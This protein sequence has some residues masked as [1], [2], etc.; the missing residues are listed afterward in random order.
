MYT[1]FT[2]P[3]NTTPVYEPLSL[4][5]MMQGN[6]AIYERGE[7]NFQKIQGLIDAAY[8]LPSLQGKDTEVKNK[9]IQSY[10]DNVAQLA[11]GNLTDP[12]SA[13]QIENY[14]SRVTRDP[15][16][17]NIVQ[18][19][20]IVGQE[21]KKRAE[22][23]AKGE[24]YI[25]PVCEEAQE[26]L[27][28]GVF[29]ADKKFSQSGW[30]NPDKAKVIKEARELSKKLVRDPVTGLVNEVILPEDVIEKY[31]LLTEN[32][33]RFLKSD[34]HRFQKNTKDVDWTTQGQNFINQQAEVYK[35]KALEAS[36]NQ[37]VEGY[38]MALNQYNRLSQLSDPSLVGEELKEQ[39][40]KSSML[41]D[42]ERIGFAN[43]LVSFKDFKVAPMVMEAKKFANQ[44]ALLEMKLKQDSVDKLEQKKQELQYKEDLKRETLWITGKIKDLNSAPSS[45]IEE[46]NSLPETKM[47]ID[48]NT[49]IPVETSAAVEDIFM[50]NAFKIKIPLQQLTTT[51]KQ[52]L[53]GKGIITESDVTSKTETKEVEVLPESYKKV[54]N[55]IYLYYPGKTE[56]VVRTIPKTIE[57]PKTVETPQ[58][59]SNNEDPNSF[60]K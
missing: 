26:Y 7:K 25:C 51:E 17:A 8:N 19:A 35:Q 41:E 42:I 6:K 36:A 24:T 37:D 34:M 52:K 20:T 11:K 16:I 58:I 22:A 53:S 30:I 57:T 12:K 29:I 47:T 40:F 13:A 48:E 60:F 21:E 14:I 43:D 56:P 50:N 4:E 44:K 23:E 31:Q 54:G 38:Q 28:Q 15:Q 18:R 9:I 5:V 27:N 49:G 32:D 45:V 2:T 55:K 33:P 1:H 3:V 10:M 39:Y 46:L 59:Q